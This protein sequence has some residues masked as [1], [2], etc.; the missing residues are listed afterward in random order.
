MITLITGGPGNG[1]T[2][3]VV[4]QILTIQEQATKA[5]ARDP[6]LPERPI[7]VW[8]I[9][10]L[11]LPHTMA[12]PFADWTHRVKSPED[13]SLE[14]DQF[15]LPT[16][17]IVVVD[18]CQTLFRV[19]A[20]SAKVPPQVSA[21]ERHRHQGLDFFLITQKPSLIDANVRA[22]VGRHIHIDTNWAGRRLFE[23]SEC[24]SPS[25]R[26]DQGEAIKRRYK[27]PQRVFDLYKSADEHHKPKRRSPVTLIV[28]AVAVLLVV[29][30]VLYMRARINELT[31]P[32]VSPEKS[33][34]EGVRH[35]PQRA[36]DASRAVASS[37]E[38]PRV[39]AWI[40]S[41]S[42]VSVGGKTLNRSWVIRDD[43]GRSVRVH[44][45]QGEGLDATCRYRGQSVRAGVPAQSEQMQMPRL[46]AS[47][48][49]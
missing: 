44:D 40:E 6:S 20:S 45:C 10:D 41:A 18:E 46:T 42:F 28:L 33:R 24:K 22:L 47:S 26:V 48:T 3:Y 37:I 11:V 16:G 29:V 32:V 39:T 17:A 8:G 49:L 15:C 38:A 21:F 43:Q 9:P 30:L 19:R 2:S 23:W 13:P 5:R 4:D 35:E 31:T 12:P 36:G 1:K 34:P 27:L 14:F 7:L 25:S